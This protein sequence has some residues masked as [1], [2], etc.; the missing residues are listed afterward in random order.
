MRRNGIR[1]V[2]F[3]KESPKDQDMYRTILPL[4][5]MMV[6]TLRRCCA[7]SKKVKVVAM[8]SVP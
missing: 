7:Q 6:P 1:I 4:E 2:M 8:N 5:M 3:R